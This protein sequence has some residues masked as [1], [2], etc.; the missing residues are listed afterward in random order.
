MTSPWNSASHAEVGK[1]FRRTAEA[2]PDLL[3]ALEPDNPLHAA[4]LLGLG[5][6]LRGVEQN[7]A[8][9]RQ[10]Q[11]RDIPALAREE[12]GKLAELEE[13]L[14]IVE[15]P[16]PPERVTIGSD[17]ALHLRLKRLGFDSLY[18][19]TDGVTVPLAQEGEAVHVSLVWREQP[20]N[21]VE[22]GRAL[23]WAA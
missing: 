22:D 10:G 6:L 16:T 3:T 9:T 14:T 19:R 23:L 11:K 17:F 2:M 7:L 12:L 8:Y 21:A 5:L 13:R 18:S 4:F 20:G 1:A 15:E